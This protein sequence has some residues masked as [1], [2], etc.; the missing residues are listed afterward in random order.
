[1]ADFVHL[2]V[3]TDFS[4]LDGACRADRLAERVKTLGMGA[5]AISDHGSVSGVP[6]FNKAAKSAGLKPIIG[7]ELY[8]AG[9]SRLK[10]LSDSNPTYHMGVIARNEDGYRNLMRLSTDAQR[11]GFHYKPRTDIDTLAQHKDG[12]IAFS[13][14][15]QGMIPQLLL[16]GRTDEARAAADRFISI[17]GREHFIIELMNH[18]ISEQVRLLAPLRAIAKEF[19]LKTVATNDVHYIAKEHADAHDAMLCVQTG[20]KLSDSDRMRYDPRQFWL[21]TPE[22]MQQVFAEMPEAMRGTVEV[23]DMCE[24]KLDFKGKHYPTFAPPPGYQTSAEYLEHCCAQGL[25]E[26]YGVDYYAQTGAARPS[27]APVVQTDGMAHPDAPAIAGRLKHE[28]DVISRTGFTDYFLVVGDFVNWAKEQKIP[29]GPGRGSGAGCMVAYTMG[30]TAI[31]PHKYGLLFERFLNPERVSPPDLDI[32][33]C[34]RRRG[35]V[36]EYVRQKY[37]E[38]CVSGII[39]FNTLGAKACIRDLCRVHG[40]PLGETDKLAKLISEEPDAEL[41][42]AHDENAE[43]RGMVASSPTFQTIFEQAQVLEGLVRN[44]G[45]HASGIL[46]ASKPLEDVVPMVRQGDEGEMVAG[47]D[48]ETVAEMG[49]LKMDFLGLKT[50]SVISDAQGHIRQQPGMEDFDVEKVPLDDEDTFKLL[51]SGRTIGVFQFESSGMQGLCRQ[52]NVSKF[53]EIAAAN[54]L[55]RPGPMDL[56]PEYIRGKNDPSTVTYLHPSLEGICRETYGIMVYQEQVMQA[57]QIVAGYSLGQADLLRRAMGKKKPEEMAK[58][59]SVFVEGAARVN[60]IDADKANGIFDILERFAG[61]GF[62]KSHSVGYATLAYQTAYLKAHHPAEFMA[63]LLTSE[64]GDT[65][66]CAKICQEVRAMGL[67]VLGPDVNTSWSEFRPEGKGVRYGLSGIKTVGTAAADTIVSAREEHGLFESLDDL[68]ARV[69]KRAVSRRTI[70]ALIKTGAFGGLEAKPGRL[71]SRLDAAIA[72]AEDT[73]QM[74]RSGQGLLF[75]MPEAEAAV[76]DGPSEVDFPRA[77][78]LAAEKEFFGFYLSGH[79]MDDIM[80]LVES[81]STH[82]PSDLQTAQDRTAFRLCGLVSELTVKQAKKDQRNWAM[83]VLDTPHGGYPLHA[84]SDAYEKIFDVIRG[85]R[86][87]VLS[88]R[89]LRGE[90]GVRL[91]VSDMVDLEAVAPAVISHVSIAVDGPEAANFVNRAGALAKKAPGEVE[92]TVEN[93]S[94]GSKSEYSARIVLGSLRT[95]FQHPAVLKDQFMVDAKPFQPNTRPIRDPVFQNR[96]G[97]EPTLV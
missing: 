61:Y 74:E 50:L 47:F 8:L 2:H 32:D 76:E 58:Q 49:L 24:L 93:V 43:F 16:Q 17:F 30:I 28:L 70:E 26:R 23:A 31:D 90:D 46:I 64:I 5:I 35:D 15:M 33:F 71:L 38:R 69:D 88:G 53:E 39:T 65:E 55:F 54:A 57:A 3:H 66:K 40:V 78:V 94:D 81:L 56:I 82:L 75:D 11:N 19:G 60:Q 67:E 83:F 51:R 97:R 92:M 20:S 91:S 96:F 34:K 45:K 84:Y 95:M 79:P 9:D 12:L 59:R 21:K 13:G 48:G 68:V 72:N 29:V 22:E 18:G 89:V 62:N 42:S 86:P 73:R 41:K 37:G 63:A 10:K 6:A 87:V 36:I 85:D 27:T 4:T 14:C 52:I 1:M 80:P 7:C 77:A 25:A 44:P